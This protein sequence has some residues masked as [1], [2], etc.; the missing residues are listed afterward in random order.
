MNIF[1]L[2]TSLTKPVEYS[3]D[4]IL[5]ISLVPE[6]RNTYFNFNCDTLISEK[7]QLINTNKKN[8]YL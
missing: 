2:D 6:I 4:F 3:L 1:V 7:I 8:I 5:E